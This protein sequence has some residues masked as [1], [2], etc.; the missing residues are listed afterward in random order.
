MGCF[1]AFCVLRIDREVSL[2]KTKAQYP[3]MVHSKW[4]SDEVS[5]FVYLV[6]GRNKGRK[7]T[8]KEKAPMVQELLQKNP[9]I[10]KQAIA[11]E[12]GIGVA[13]VYRILQEGKG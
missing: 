13:S 7:P 3:S 4:P 12:L 11:D 5:P 1:P 8:A 2:H 9:K 6:A 10:T